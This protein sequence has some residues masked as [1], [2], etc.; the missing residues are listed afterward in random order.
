M[1]LTVLSATAFSERENYLVVAWGI[2]IFSWVAQLIGHGFAEGR[3]PAFLDNLLG[4]GSLLILFDPLNIQFFFLAVVL[5]PFFVH[6]EIL[7]ALGFRPE[8]HKRVNN[9]IGM[10]IARI[11][12]LDAEKKRKSQ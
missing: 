3:A 9:A 6:L 10:E 5:A 1:I 12:R 11:R 7:F 4:G 8:M 2:H